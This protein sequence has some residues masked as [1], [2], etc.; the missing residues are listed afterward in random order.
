MFSPSDNAWKPASNRS[1]KKSKQGCKTCKT[2]KVKCDEQR[3]VCG[4]CNTYYSS[5][6]QQCDYDHS[7]HGPARDRQSSGRSTTLR[8]ARSGREVPAKHVIVTCVNPNMNMTLPRRRPLLPS[9][10]GGVALDPFNTIAK[11]DLP[12]A[13]QLL[14]HYLSGIINK[15]LPAGYTPDKNPL[16]KGLWPL[17]QS[18]TFFFNV[19]LQV[20]AVE[21]E[22]L[23]GRPNTFH[24]EKYTSESIQ[25]LR[26]R[27][28]D[29]KIAASDETISAVATLATLEYGKK[30]MV[31][32]KMHVDG[33]KRMINMRGGLSKVRESSQTTATM[34]HW[35]TMLL[36]QDV[37]KFKI[38][39][40]PAGFCC[41]ALLQYLISI[42][43]PDDYDDLSIDE[44]NMPRSLQQVPSYLDLESFG[45]E[46]RVVSLMGRTRRIAEQLS[47]GNLG[48]ANAPDDLHWQFNSLLQSLCH[49][50]VKAHAESYTARI[51]ESSRHATALFLFLPFD[52]H[53][54]D[55]RLVINAFLH[56]LKFALKNLVPSLGTQSRLL[57]WLLSVGGVTSFDTPER[58]WFVG[59]LV[60]VVAHLELRSWDDFSSTL[61][62]IV[63]IR[64]PYL[65]GQFRGL[66]EEIKLATETLA[67]QD[68]YTSIIFD[69]RGSSAV[70]ISDTDAEQETL[71]T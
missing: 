10:V 58:E 7:T 45:I 21:M 68:P 56:K 47:S 52:N 32:M 24:S 17:V 8:S 48:Q 36:M 28:L 31:T 35:F 3:P 6:I 70:P 15:C 23:Q 62:G 55:P 63:Y 59:H 64:G 54:P 37:R 22:Y 25:M 66:W 71:S 29:P 11:S 61:E 9:T 5:R 14:H 51:T 30:N 41:H 16:I 13:D 26:K 38:S 65:D 12:S 18:D 2:R 1:K 43:P 27:I 67:E 34:A 4:N 44:L 57:L 69:S 49:L 60:P 20:S 39:L 46:H 53:Y 42:F 33:L 19:I 50:Q 40:F